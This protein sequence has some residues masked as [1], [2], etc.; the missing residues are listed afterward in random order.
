MR[1]RPLLFAALV[2]AAAAA[3]ATTVLAWPRLARPELVLAA[4]STFAA[5]GQ[6]ADGGLSLS[7]AA[8]WP[9]V[10]RVRFGAQ[11]YADDIGT[12]L[13]QLRDPND[14]APLG[15]A[16]DAHRW[17]WGGAWRAE[18]DAWSVG[19]WTGGVSGDFGFWRVEDDR[20]GTT[21]AAGSAVGFRI[22]ADARRPLGRGKDVG[23]EIN[24]HRLAQDAAASWQRVDRYASAAI[25][26]RWSGPDEND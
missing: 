25:Q 7:A 20:R 8:L 3:P 19:R 13:V 23:V 15:L 1:V 5:T 26:F 14:G 16:A 6:P 22:G 21:F 10:D 18:A 4:G 9:V 11:L 24:Y 12:H 17:A 2:V